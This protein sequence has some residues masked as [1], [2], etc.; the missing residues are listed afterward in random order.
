MGGH[1]GEE[2]E[3]RHVAVVVSEAGRGLRVHAVRDYIRVGQHA[4]HMLLLIASV[5]VFM[6]RERP[7]GLSKFFSRSCIISRQVGRSVSSIMGAL[8]KKKS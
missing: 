2:G 5:R 7:V 4:W 6:A 1:G 3:E 8:L